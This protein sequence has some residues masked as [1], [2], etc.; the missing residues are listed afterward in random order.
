D[1]RLHSKHGDLQL[2]H[3]TQPPL[4]FAAGTSEAG[5]TG[6]T[7]P[8]GMSLTAFIGKDVRDYL[9]SRVSALAQSGEARVIARPKV[10][11][12]DNTE[13]LLEN[14]SEFYVSVSGF[15]DAGLF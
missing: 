5:Q 14:L 8:T 12:L 11:T 13:A 1:W 10:M 4:T 3:G 6:I 2:G 9:L 7:T 15:Q